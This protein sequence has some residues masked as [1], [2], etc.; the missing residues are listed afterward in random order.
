LQIFFTDAL[1]FT[2]NRLKNIPY[3]GI[4]LGMQIA[5]VE[6]ARNIVGFAGANST[7]FNE[8]TPYPVV[9]M[10]NEWEE[11]GGIVEKRDEN[12]DL[13][14]TMRLGTQ[15]CK[16][17]ANSLAHEIYATDTIFERHRHRYEVNNNFIEK[18]KQ[19]GLVVSGVSAGREGLVEIIEL[20]EHQWFFACQFHPE[21]TSNPKT[22][23][24]LFIS[25]VNAAL[26]NRKRRKF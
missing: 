4:C 23:H 16:L 5:I 9:A 11:K 15:E 6:F 13:G 22:G 21:F 25:Y 20:P 12:S 17:V 2:A 19:N 3:L 26:N 24:P 18:L 8:E 10:I 1:T 14:G 7:E